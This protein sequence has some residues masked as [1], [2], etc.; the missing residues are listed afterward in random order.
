MSYNKQIS[1]KITSKPPRILSSKIL[2]AY[3]IP[4]VIGLSAWLVY[5]LNQSVDDLSVSFINETSLEVRDIVQN[6]I[7]D[8]NRLVLSTTDLNY[9]TADDILNVKDNNRVYGPILNYLESVTN[10]VLAN[11]QGSTYWIHK[12]DGELV[13][14]ITKIHENQYE[15][16]FYTWKEHCQI[17]RT[18]IYSK[19]D[20]IIYDPRIR[21]WYKGAVTQNP[22]DVFW[23]KPYQFYSIRQHGITA[24]TYFM[25]ENGDTIVSAYDI[26]LKD[27]N[28]ISR[29]IQ[30]TPHSYAFIV[31]ADSLSVIG[32]PDK[33]QF[34]EEDSIAKYTMGNVSKL[35][36]ASLNM[37]IN[38]WRELDYSHKPFEIEVDGRDWWVGFQP[39]VSEDEEKLFYVVMLVPEADFRSTINRSINIL[40]G[41]IMIVV[42]LIVFIIRA[43]RRIHTQNEKLRDKRLKIS[44]QKKFIEAKNKQIMDSI[45]YTK[46]IQSTMLPS[47]EQ[48]KGFFENSFVLYL[49]KDIVSGDFYWIEELE[50][51][52]IITAADCTGHGVP[53]AV[54]S[55]IG[56]GGI[57]SAIKERSYLKPNLILEHLQ[58]VI[59]SY[60]LK[61]HNR[62]VNDGMDISV[63]V[64][65][66]ENL[67]ITYAG[68][69]NPFYI[70]RHSDNPLLVNDALQQPD[71]QMQGR[72]LFVIKADRKGVE[73]SEVLYEFKNNHVIL[74]EGDM[75]YQF[76]DGFA[77]QFGGEKG[78]KL[79]TKRF[80]ELILAVSQDPLMK[81]QEKELQEYFMQ[82]KGSE[83]QVDDVLVM[84]FRV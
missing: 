5:D 62:G 52:Y 11:T 15:R 4:I 13:N 38:A 83:E 39:I 78:K 67:S 36:I 79:N 43:Y 57:K 74:E 48:V 41:S 56:Y 66:K 23:T 76:T 14:R 49:P 59:N 6:Y 21:P 84:G 16:T 82:W 31:T 58:L 42:A 18:R 72:A 55:M 54:L 24:A 30:L 50:G 45:Y 63:C 70:V 68:A 26:L 33:E 75:V 77:D 1:S 35:G 44:R 80:K 71:I 2:F 9:K 22:K 19:S 20:T 27:F 25:A 12:R 61:A 10:I 81:N 46:T 53:G 3:F 34:D 69:K 51:H 8:V 64:F 40:I 28:N 47:P 73:P 37:G 29:S 17:E 32:F 7:N 60:F 65:N